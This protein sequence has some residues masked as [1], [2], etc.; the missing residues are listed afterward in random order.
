MKFA[1]ILAGGTGQRMGNV[2]LPKQ[3]LSI[4][5]KE[6]I[7]HTLEKFYLFKEE[8]DQVIVIV[9]PNWTAYAQDLIKGNF[10]VN[11]G[12]FK[13]IEGGETRN[14]TVQKGIEY[15]KGHY[16]VDDNS[17]VLTHDAVRPFISYKII[18]DNIDYTLKYGAVD[19]VINSIDTIVVSDDG[20]EISNIPERA[21]YYQG[22]TPQ[23]FK[24]LELAEVYNS[25]NKNQLDQATDVATLY[26]T[27]NK[28]VF[29]VK[30]NQLNFKIT[31]PFD[32]KIAKALLEQE[33]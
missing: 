30:G 25:L 10:K 27:L 4:N 29:L 17:I 8:L 9:H 15:I 5:N 2:E 31:T 32:L 3:F 33:S 16:E 28:K 7:L 21:K 26:K 23:S 13:V 24:V 22:Q 1:L 19:T 12:F 20:I 18:R 11:P 6:I 14:D